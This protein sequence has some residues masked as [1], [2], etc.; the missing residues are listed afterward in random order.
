M[1]KCLLIGI[2]M[3]A[4]FISF[5]ICS[6][7][8]HAQ[9]LTLTGENFMVLD[10]E[11]FKKQKIVFT[12]ADGDWFAT[13]S[14]S[15]G[16]IS[17]DASVAQRKL[18]LDIEWDG[19]NAVHAINNEIR[20]QQRKGEFIISMDDK[21]IYGDGLNAYPSGEDEVKIVIHSIDEA[22]LSGELSGMITQ[23]N[24]EVK[25]SGTFNLE[26]K[27]TATSGKKIV[28]LP[29]KN[30][31]NVVHDKLTGAENRSTS[32]SE[33]Q[34]DLDVRQ[35]LRDAFEPVISSLQ[36][37]AWQIEQQTGLDPLDGVQRGSEKE[38]FSTSYDLRLSL[39]QASPVFAQYTEKINAL[40]EKSRNNPTKENFEEVMKV[41]RE[42]N[43]LTHISIEA[44]VNNR[45]ASF[46][47]FKGGIKVSNIADNVFKIQGPYMRSRMGGGEDASVDATIFL[48]GRWKQPLVQKL[49]EKE[50]EVN[51]SAILNNPRSQLKAENMVIRIE[52]SPTL[53]DEII[54]NIDIGKLRAMVK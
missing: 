49:D 54:K 40:T 52:C 20:H 15:H 19:K 14:D 21:A 10:G 12:K 44:F 41:G 16:T 36:K 13:N 29:Y 34:Y 31:D 27:Q 24:E 11:R 51:S 39:S 22:N 18:R 53:A 48:I 26:K 25:V 45:S 50:A 9:P 43:S 33:A 1:K 28:T 35:T 30:Y 3:K 42:M 47:N 23:G 6:V 46:S 32:E 5:F 8:A 37:D 4:L 2:N 17:F 38:L 7:S